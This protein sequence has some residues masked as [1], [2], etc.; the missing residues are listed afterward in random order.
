MRNEKLHDSSKSPISFKSFILE[1]LVSSH[2][3]VDP[4]QPTLTF[5]QRQVLWL[6]NKIL[7]DVQQLLFWGDQLLKK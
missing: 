4:N 1:I 6:Q 3:L 2:K 7:E 5:S